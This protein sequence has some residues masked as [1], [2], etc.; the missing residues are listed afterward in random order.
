MRSLNLKKNEQLLISAYEI[1]FNSRSFEVIGNG[2]ESEDFMEEARHYIDS[3]DKQEWFPEA[4]KILIENSYLSEKEL[5]SL[6]AE[7]WINKRMNAFHLK[8]E[9]GGDF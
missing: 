9:F 3:I 2:T 7:S 5:A 8:V 4:R 1:A 6:A